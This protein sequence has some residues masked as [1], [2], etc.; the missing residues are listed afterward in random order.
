LSSCDDKPVPLRQ[1]F[2]YPV[3]IAIANYAILEVL[4]LSYNSL[5]S[6]FLAMPIEIGGVGLDPLRIGYIMS[7]NRAFVGVFLALFA[8]KLVRRFGER[9]LFVYCMSAF[10]LLWPLFP[11]INLWAKHFGMTMGVWVGIVMMGL[12]FAMSDMAY[13]YYT[14]LSFHLSSCLTFLSKIAFS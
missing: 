5:I 13:S 8:D 11:A 7:A 2:V 1:L 12:S 3:M 9:Q 14:S 10:L 6:L 4:N